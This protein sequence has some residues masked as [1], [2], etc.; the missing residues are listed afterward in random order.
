MTAARRFYALAACASL[1]A[2]VL[3]AAQPPAQRWLAKNE[4][5]ARTN[6]EVAFIA[7]PNKGSSPTTISVTKDGRLWFTESTGN[8]IGSVQ[9]DGTDLHE[10]PLPN[11]DSSPRIIAVGS[12]GNL[13]FS[14]HNGNRIGRLTP[15]GELAEF[16]LPTPASQPR[17]TALGADGNL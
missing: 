11:A 10:Y 16:A 5:L 14:E 3:D 6:G 4:T 17:A 2:D 1:L 7:L 12:D 8:R 13:W 9:P 15:R